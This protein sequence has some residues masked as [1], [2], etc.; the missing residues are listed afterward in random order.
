[1]ISDARLS[2]VKAIRAHVRN[3]QIVPDEPVELPEGM[4]VE[5]M[6]PGVEIEPTREDLEAI[7]REIELSHAEYERGEFVSARDLVAVLKSPRS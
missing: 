3:G 6:I 1:M 4:V 7:E 2:S 5:V